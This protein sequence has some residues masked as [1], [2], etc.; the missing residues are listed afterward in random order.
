MPTTPVQFRHGG[1][2]VKRREVGVEDTDS[3]GAIRDLPPL[4]QATPNQRSFG[5]MH[6]LVRDS[7]EAERVG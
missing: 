5:V 2:R 1:E 4:L 7:R 3:S 6:I